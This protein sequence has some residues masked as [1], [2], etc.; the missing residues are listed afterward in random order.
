[1]MSRDLEQLPQFAFP[2]PAC[3]VRIKNTSTESQ[4]GV[5]GNVVPHLK[6]NDVLPYAQELWILICWLL[7]QLYNFQPL[8]NEARLA[9]IM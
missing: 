1:M 6:A 9:P 8:L 2:E 4:Q 7:S 5:E 3:C